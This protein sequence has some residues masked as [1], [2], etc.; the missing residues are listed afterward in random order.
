M[1]MMLEIGIAD[2]ARH[3]QWWHV[4]WPADVV[5][6]FKEFMDDIPIYSLKKI[7]IFL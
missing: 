6:L 5:D 3:W 7:R 1:L 4:C 2:L